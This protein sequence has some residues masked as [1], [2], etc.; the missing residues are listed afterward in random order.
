MSRE[1]ERNKFK[2]SIII[3][4]YNRYPLNVNTLVAL[5]NQ[6]FEKT[7]MEVILIDDASTDDTALLREYQ[8]TYSFQYIRTPSQLGPSGARN[9]GL[10]QA[11]GKIIIFLDAEMMVG[12]DYVKTH[13]LQ[14][15]RNK[16][17]I[18]VIGRNKSK[19]YTYFFSDFNLAQFKQIDNL[20]KSS[21]FVKQRLSERL[22]LSNISI[23]SLRA[24][25]EKKTKPIQLIDREEIKEFT[26]LKSYLICYEN[27]R[28]LYRY[29]MKH[30]DSRLTWQLCLG[31]N[32]SIKRS[33][34]S[35]VGGY[36][37]DFEGWGVEDNEFAYRLYKAGA[38][39]V[40]SPELFR[41]HQE[42]PISQSKTSELFKNKIL[43]KQKHPDIDIH[44]LSLSKINGDDFQ[45]VEEVLREHRALCKKYPGKFEYFK[46]VIILLLQQID[47]LRVNEKPIRKLLETS[48]IHHNS[49]RKS[50]LYSERKTI[51]AYGKY[52]N[53]LR[54]FDILAKK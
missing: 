45:F 51:K 8:P 26:R 25:T 52:K 28:R 35:K 37:E 18:V 50:R 41:Y 34:L 9:I 54:L 42:H 47:K 4:S 44:I 15:Q 36:D 21:P 40:I 1:S 30:P 5:E 20:A 29:I 53:L 39:F 13:Y 32:H 31:S 22:Q 6:N 43:F 10:K 23:E 11:K 27:S 24:F 49:K 14:H 2:V 38:K 33:L 48:G 17:Q 19:I 46:N 12:P 3:P 7:K 16:K